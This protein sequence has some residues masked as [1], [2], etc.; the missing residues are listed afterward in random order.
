MGKERAFIDSLIIIRGTT[1]SSLYPDA[2]VVEVTG[3]V[4]STADEPFEQLYIPA[5]QTTVEGIEGCSHTVAG[6]AEGECYEWEVQAVGQGM[7]SQWSDGRRLVVSSDYA[8]TGLPAFDAHPSAPTGRTAIYN[9]KGTRVRDMSQPG[10]YIV[11]GDGTARKVVV[12]LGV[13]R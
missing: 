3:Q 2:K 6:L 12:E 7:T 8:A 1:A 4:A 9:I 10:V 5:A 11:R 13:R